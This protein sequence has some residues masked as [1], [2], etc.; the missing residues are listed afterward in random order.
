MNFKKGNLLTLFL[1]FLLLLIPFQ[2]Y[3]YSNALKN[4]VRNDKKVELKIFEDLSDINI[5]AGANLTASNFDKSRTIKLMANGQYTIEPKK[6]QVSRFL[7]QIFVTED[8]KK[9][10][11][12]IAEVEQEFPKYNYLV[13][14]EEQLYKV[15]VGNFIS[16]SETEKVADDFK[17]AGWNTWIIEDKSSVELLDSKQL[18]IRDNHG[19][20]VFENGTIY[21]EGVI[22]IKNNLYNGSFKFEL[23]SNNNIEIYNNIDFLTLEYGLLLNQMSDTNNITL[24][25][26]AAILNRSKVLNQ[27]LSESPPYEI[28]GY[29]GISQLTDII[30]I[31]VDNTQVKVIYKNNSPYYEDIDIRSLAN[32]YSSSNKIILENMKGVEIRDLNTVLE[33]NIAVDASIDLGLNYK[34]IR[35]L[36]WNGNRIINIINLDTLKGR[37]E[38]FSTLSN[39]KINGLS[40]LSSLVKDNEALVG[41]NGGFYNYQGKPLGLVMVDGTIVSEPLYNRAALGI[42]KTGEI[43]IDNISWRG[44]LRTTNNENIIID[45][46]NRKPNNENEIILYNKYF[47]DKTPLFEQYTTEIVVEEGIIFDIKRGES[48]QS[49]IPEDGFVL[50][51]FDQEDRY[52]DFEINEKVDYL[53]V[54]NPDWQ[55]KDVM[56]IM[57]GGPKLI[58]D[59]KVDLTDRE[60]LF[61]VDI[62]EGRAPRTA[63]GLTYDHHLLLVT[64]DG[65]QPEISIGITLRELAEYLKTLNIKEAMNLD[66]GDSSQMVIRGYTFN[67]PSGYR[68]IATGILIK[69]K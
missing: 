68:D 47:S 57:G 63:V 45:A 58:T 32:K 69:K 33:E 40:S 54:F 11:S 4:F 46:V 49:S 50:K 31:A 25:K 9:A 16:E 34:E 15:R 14:K 36:T 38:V 59:G 5:V 28:K 3:A 24:L 17:Q 23:N 19:N 37:H 29:Q 62:A 35:Q 7:I 8:Q 12:I 21:F 56:S 26:T 1:V 52:D 22:R 60:E 30:K 43:L 44:V 64:V 41:I 18:V 6:E 48:I 55:K 65:R 20:I 42:T 10:D 2:T 39:D 27:I 67:N 61:N 53:N 51:I 13:T 66:G